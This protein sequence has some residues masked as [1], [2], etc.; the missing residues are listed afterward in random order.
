M[1]TLYRSDTLQ[2]YGLKSQLKFYSHQ[3][4][5]LSDCGDVLDIDFSNQALGWEGVILEKGRSPHFYPDN[6]YTPYFYFALAL[7]KELNWN[8][9][10]GENLT[11]IKAVA[12]D[13][14]I[15]PPE[16]PFTHDISEPCHFVILA[17]ESRLFLDSCPLNIEKMNLQFLNNYNVSDP[18]IKGIMDLFILEV[19]AKGR[20]GLNYVNQLISLLANHYVQ[21]Y[22]N[23]LDLQKTLQAESKFDQNQMDKVDHYIDKHIA[24]PISVDDLAD[25]L[26]CS[27][28][29]FLRE[30]KKLMGVTPYQYIIGKRLELAKQKLVN[31]NANIAEISQQCGFNDQSHF[32]RAFKNQYGITP[33]Q[34]VKQS[35]D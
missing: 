35:N 18:V 30:F 33:G 31:V 11:A 29:Y 3:S 28:F 34:Y 2:V 4:K 14:W 21:N 12:D 22:S 10:S 25:L 24:H 8:I 13:I 15:N 27:K 5:T 20:N 32:T 23:Y 19:K 1:L 26:S 7:D 6:V 17:I 9:G 16:T